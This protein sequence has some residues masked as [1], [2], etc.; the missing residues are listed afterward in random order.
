ML[1]RAGRRPS[2]VITGMCTG[3]ANAIDRVSN[4]LFMFRVL[5]FLQKP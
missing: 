1:G 5:E 3:E 2:R 4:A